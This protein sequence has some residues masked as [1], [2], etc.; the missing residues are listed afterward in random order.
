MSVI[1]KPAANLKS[2]SAR[3]RAGR[4]SMN[5]V[6]LSVPSDGLTILVVDID[7]T[8]A[9][10]G[11]VQN[12]KPLPCRQLFSVDILR[13][14]D[15]IGARAA[16]VKEVVAQSGLSPHVIVN[17]VPG[18]IDT[19]LD[20]VLYA[21][22]ILVLN[23]RALF[24]HWSRLSGYCVPLDRYAILMLTGEVFAG[25]AQEAS[26][27]LGIF[28][29]TGLDAAYLDRGVAFRGGGWALELGNMRVRGEGCTIEVVRTDC[30]ETYASGR[31]LADL[32][33][34]YGE[35]AESVFWA[36]GKA[37]LQDEP[38]QFVRDQAYGVAAAVVMLSPTTIVLCGGVLNID[39]YPRDNL[40]QL[41][42]AHAPISET[43]CS[44]DLRW[45]DHGWS[46]VLDGAPHVV[47]DRWLISPSEIARV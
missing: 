47:A 37:A 25:I 20:H 35:T 13:A 24:R 46:N 43:G 14:G 26:R 40:S 29:G 9:E 22:N 21:G 38:V 19:D 23:G 33:T 16:M 1:S 4:S 45:A 31:A 32:A 12:G 5:A 34:R 28:F 44:M 41:I 10:F 18:L 3:N 36:A 11:F 7:G 30:L 2:Y 6:P 42:E 17:T 39:G 8:N 15:P 27:V